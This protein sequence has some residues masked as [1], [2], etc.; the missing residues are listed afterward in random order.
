MAQ[1]SHNERVIASLLCATPRLK[2]FLKQAYISITYFI[3][4]KKYISRVLNLNTEICFIDPLE[5][6]NESFFGYYDKS[7]ENEND[8]II[9]YE[10]DIVTCKKPTSSSPILIIA[11]N[12]KNHFR[13]FISESFAYNWQQGSRA[14]WIS[15]DK[16]IFNNY[17]PKFGCYEAHIYSLSKNKIS[18]TY[19]LPVQD[20]Y[21]DVYYLSINYRRIMRLRPDYG[22]RNLPLPDDNEMRNI[23]S[24]GIW[25]V[26]LKTGNQIL[27]VSLKDVISL[28]PAPNF[29]TSLHKFNHVMISPNGENFIFIHRWYQNGKRFDRLMLY[30][31]GCLKILA[32]DRMVSHMCWIDDAM[33][34]GYLQYDGNSG[35]YFINIH[36]GCISACDTLNNMNNGDGHP[37]CYK[38][39]IV[40]D[41]YPDK[42]R[43]QHLTLYN[44]KTNEVIPIVE[45]FQALRY[46]GECRCDMHPRFSPDG[47]R[48]FFDT[49]YTG[50]RRLAYIDV[51][52]ITKR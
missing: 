10:S 7:P 19:S 4:R 50:K 27:L 21:K 51:S 14:Q 30:Q 17:N 8:W 2:T 42:S 20:S 38:D 9:C 6:E 37:A 43:L 47:K 1:F 49:V 29:E 48:V 36:T 46:N 33:L 28:R 3:Q 18:E 16:I 41:S 24:D 52:S 11:L 22:Y 32:N 39:W 35:F 5:P 15:N 40:F 44:F 34:F 13:Q 45:V 26:D 25:K 31:K 23:D 12:L